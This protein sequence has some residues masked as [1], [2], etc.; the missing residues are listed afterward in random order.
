MLTFNI[1]LLDFGD[2]LSSKK[3]KLLESAQK[4]FLKGQYDR[5]VDDYRQLM[6][7]EPSDLRHRQRVAEILTKANKKDEAIK[8]YALL[9]KHY[10]DTIHY[11]K[12]IAVYKQIQK[13]DPQNAETS[14]TL[15]SLN[16][17]QGLI[18]NATAE[19]ASAVQIYEK[20]GE[21]LKALK[22]LESMMA[23][24]SGNSAVKLRI[25][26]KYFTTG[27]EEKSFE[28]FGSLLRELKERNDES[29]FSLIS[30]R[31]VSFFDNRAE[32]IL[33]QIAEKEAVDYLPIEPAP[34]ISSENL[35]TPDAT[36][37]TELVTA[38]ASTYTSAETN[39]SIKSSNQVP[40]EEIE[41]IEDILPFEDED[42]TDHPMIS[43]SDDEW[44]EEIDLLPVDFGQA[45]EELPQTENEILEELDAAVELDELELV[46]EIDDEEPILTAT[47][48]DAQPLLDAKD[49]DLGKE[50]SIFADEIDFDLFS[51]QT[52]DA[53]FD[54]TESGFKKGELDNEDAESHYSLGLAYKEMGLFDE[55]IGEFI[56][57]SHSSERRIDSLILQ[58]VCLREIGNFVKAFEILSDVLQDKEI[59]EDESLGVKYELAL[60][61]ETSGEFEKARSLLTDIIAA[62]PTFSDVATRLKNLSS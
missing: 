16:E 21:N 11:L 61:H 4:N 22:T 57:A 7:I 49:F 14:L 50:L 25:A 3:T 17:K 40:D 44:E 1:I 26:E 53:T 37:G 45:P 35:I 41:F 2:I 31:F 23:L 8:E 33:E 18:G 58:G 55:A 46:L 19:Y 5:A 24:D 38:E 47:S 15:A 12:A 54:I 6:Q 48:P 43:D 13:L 32:E 52:S 30:E 34:S 60:C 51:S 9:A 62:R 20:N 42:Q 28:A 56:V 29:G 59:T 36:P 10:I 27:S 39:L